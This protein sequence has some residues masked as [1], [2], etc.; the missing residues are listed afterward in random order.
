MPERSSVVRLHARPVG[1]RLCPGGLG[2]VSERVLDQRL[3]E[4]H[5]R[6]FEEG[7]ASSTETAARA[8]TGALERFDQFIERSGTEVAAFAAELAVD[9]AG[10]L[11][12]R[13]IDSGVYDIERLVRDT[14]AASKVGRGHCVVHLAP[15]DHARLHGVPFRIGTELVPDPDIEPGNVQVETPQG[16]LVHDREEAL[17]SIRQE[18]LDHLS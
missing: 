16:L 11:L 5:A 15:S 6:G 13:E 10:Y 2:E 1:A 9:I 7:V 8:L 17:A 14:L 3:A 18:L 12:R 4:A